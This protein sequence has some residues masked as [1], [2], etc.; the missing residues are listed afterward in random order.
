MKLPTFSKKSL[1]SNKSSWLVLK[2]INWFLIFFFCLTWLDFRDKMLI[3]LDLQMTNGIKTLKKMTPSRL[4]CHFFKGAYLI[5]L[6]HVI[7]LCRLED[8][9]GAYSIGLTHCQRNK[10][11]KKM[12]PSCLDCHFFKGAYL[13][14]LYHIIFCAD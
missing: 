14:E 12:T 4:D 2:R 6:N 10:T 8:L 3:Q 5:G 9:K 11:W 7:F 13:I 1:I